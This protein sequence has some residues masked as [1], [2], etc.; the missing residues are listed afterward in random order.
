[1][2]VTR[3][4]RGGVGAAREPI[5]RRGERGLYRDAFVRRAKLPVAAD[6]AHELR[7]R[8]RVIERLRVRIEV[9]DP[10]LEM[11]VLDPRLGAQ[12]PQAFAAVKAQP[13]ELDDVG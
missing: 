9:Q 6:F 12:R 11:V 2:R 5:S 3:L 4:V 1:M 10:A 13:N 7:R 8:Y